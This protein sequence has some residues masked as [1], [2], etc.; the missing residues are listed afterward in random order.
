MFLLELRKAT[1][2]CQSIV[3][4]PFGPPVLVGIKRVASGP[5]TLALYFT[6]VSCPEDKASV[7]TGFFVEWSTT[8]DFL[9]GTVW[10]NTVA[11]NVD[12]IHI[13][14]CGQGIQSSPDRRLGCGCAVFCMSR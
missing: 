8:K 7:V 2:P 3:L 1:A 6:S 11:A 4:K 5:S 14:Q 9:P 10:D 12:L 13:Q